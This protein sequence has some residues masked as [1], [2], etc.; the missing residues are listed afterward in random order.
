MM[1]ATLMMEILTSLMILQ[2]SS[3]Y[4]ITN[5]KLRKSLKVNLI[6]HKFDIDVDKLEKK[7]NNDD[8]ADSFKNNL[9]SFFKNLKLSIKRLHIRFED[10][11]FS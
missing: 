10:D 4:S 5:F 9:Q 1:K 3:I 8:D 7:N 11:Y 6:H 2:M